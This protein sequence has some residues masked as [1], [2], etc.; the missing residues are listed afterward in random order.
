MSPTKRLNFFYSSK[1]KH[2]KINFYLT[3]GR[4]SISNILSITST[5]ADA[6][7]SISYKLTGGFLTISTGGSI[8]IFSYYFSILTGGI[9]GIIFFYGI[10]F[11]FSGIFYFSGFSFGG[12]Y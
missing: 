3:A 12:F 6:T 8:I 2:E 4:T 11:S 10:S 9:F 1:S 7:I 5:V